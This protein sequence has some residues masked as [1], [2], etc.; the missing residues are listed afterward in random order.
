MRD[1]QHQAPVVEAGYQPPRLRRLGT[2][3][4]LTQGGTSGPDDGLGGG[5]FS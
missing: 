3:A 2:L 4:E 1:I 5:G